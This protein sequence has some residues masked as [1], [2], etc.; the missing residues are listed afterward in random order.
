MRAWRVL[1]VIPFAVA[2]QP[3]PSGP[4]V[5]GVVLE[6]DTQTTAGEFS[7][8]ADDNQVFRYRFDPKTYVERE[9]RTIDATR[10]EPGERVEVLSDEGPGS[11]LRYARTVHVLQT[12]PPQRPVSAGRLRA[13]RTSTE[14]LL[15]A[16]TLSFAG[17]ISRLI[18]DRLVL[19]TRDAGDQTILLRQDT[20]YLEDGTV[21][22][23]AELKLN[24]RVFVRA[25]RNLYNEVEAYQVIWGSILRPR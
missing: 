18:N 10:L 15:P 4:L 24:M 21:V 22:E 16:G 3:A 13:Y 7:V 20:R 1:L 5:R 19:H 12:P 8:R 25:G 14:R 23:P 2:A 9:Q 6:R 17:V 11:M